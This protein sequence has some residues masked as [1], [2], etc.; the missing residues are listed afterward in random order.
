LLVRQGHGPV[1][2]AGLSVASGFV[3]G[4]GIDWAE[5]YR[6]LKDIRTLVKGETDD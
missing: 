2:F 6:G 5:R 1:D 3:V 4:Y